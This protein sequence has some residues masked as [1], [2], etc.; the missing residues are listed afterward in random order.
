[1]HERCMKCCW[2]LDIVEQD[3]RMSPRCQAK[4][5]CPRALAHELYQNSLALHP[6]SLSSLSVCSTHPR[7]NKKPPFSPDDTPPQ[8]IVR[9]FPSSPSPSFSS[10]P[11][12]PFVLTLFSLLFVIHVFTR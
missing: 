10:T 6:S 2:S 12:S 8:S 7:K 4:C 3:L 11:P 1:M 5:G 9:T